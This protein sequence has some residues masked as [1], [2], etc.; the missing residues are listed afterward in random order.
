MAI[1]PVKWKYIPH[2]SHKMAADHTFWLGSTLKAA[3][4]CTECGLEQ[5]KAGYSG[6]ESLDPGLVQ[7]CKGTQEGIAA[8]QLLIKERNTYAALLV[9]RAI[10]IHTP[11]VVNVMGIAEAVVKSMEEYKLLVPVDVNVKH[12]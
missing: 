10:S 9:A 11:D 5:L 7:P 1:A 2:R 6:G 12:T 3:R 8:T 4:E